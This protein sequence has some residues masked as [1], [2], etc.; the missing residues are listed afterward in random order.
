VAS[1]STL[2]RLT[3]LT[4]WFTSPLSTQIVVSSGSITESSGSAVT[5]AA[6]GVVYIALAA[7]SNVLVSLLSLFLFLSFTHSYSLCLS[8]DV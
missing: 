1:F 7:S 3:N 2:S 5:L 8:H 4:V 6:S